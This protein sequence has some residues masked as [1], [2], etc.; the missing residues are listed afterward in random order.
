MSSNLP[1]IF[2][3][4]VCHFGNR[5]KR[6]SKSVGHYQSTNLCKNPY[7]CV[8]FYFTRG[9]FSYRSDSKYTAAWRNQSN[10][11]STL[12]EPQNLKINNNLWQKVETKA[13]SFVLF[14]AYYD[15]RPT[16]ESN[17]PKI[18]ILTGFRVRAVFRYCHS[19][20]NHHETGHKI[21]RRISLPTL[22]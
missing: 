6:K 10:V 5:L 7:P 8:R 4:I 20:L 22:V 9:L 15:P 2:S 18:R 19:T 12:V 3:G 21:Y 11:C 14:S 13:S 1:R 16:F 17:L